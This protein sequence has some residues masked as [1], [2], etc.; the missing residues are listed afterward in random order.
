MKNNL[1]EKEEDEMFN[2]I[3]FDRKEIKDTDQ[4]FFKNEKD[5]NSS[6]YFLIHLDY[7][8]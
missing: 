6:E 2:E 7:R 3:E 5:K 1:N 8:I 4:T